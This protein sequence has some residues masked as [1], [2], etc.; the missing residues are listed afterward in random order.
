VPVDEH[1]TAVA[2]DAYSCSGEADLSE[3]AAQSDYLFRWVTSP[4]ARVRDQISGSDSS[5]FE[6]SI[7]NVHAAPR[8]VL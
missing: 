5:Q 1:D 3:N 4:V 6:Y 2:D 7:L 8:R